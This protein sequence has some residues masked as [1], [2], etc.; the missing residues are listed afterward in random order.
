MD[1]RDLNRPELYINRELS[2]LE[3]N[4]RVL[5]QAEDDRLPL[6]E[7]LNFLCISCSNLD[8]FFEVRALVGFSNTPASTLSRT[9]ASEKSMP[10]VPIS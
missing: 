7:R 4:H 2:L 3:F 9:A 8:E 6:L 5:E 1:E 10:P